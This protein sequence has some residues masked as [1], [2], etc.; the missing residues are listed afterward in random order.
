MPVI[1]FLPS[2][3]KISVDP[4][5]TILEAAQQAG[6]QMNVVC[7][8]QG[9]CGKCIV[10]VKAG[11]TSFDREK[12]GRFFTLEELDTGGCLACQ[13]GI[14]GDV[15]VL[16]PESSLIQEQESSS[17]PLTSRRPSLLQSGNMPWN[18]GPR[19]W[20]TLRRT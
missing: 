20:M 12:F 7:G 16:I 18:S 4:G 13:T 17:S 15:Q 6:V 2:Y 10:Q 14:L 5:I 3:R 8:G 1:T 19:P 9:K 11:K